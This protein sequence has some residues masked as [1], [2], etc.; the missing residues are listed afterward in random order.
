MRRMNSGPF[1]VVGNRRSGTS[2]LRLM[3][4]AHPRLCVPPEGGFV[5]FL[6]WYFGD[7]RF[8]RRVLELFLDRL[9][10]PEFNQ[11]WGLGRRELEAELLPRLP[12]GF[13]DIVDGVYRTYLSIRFPEAVRWGDK[14]TWYQ[15]HLPQLETYFPTAQYVHIVRDPRAVL[16]SY[17]KVPHL[18][19]DALEVAAD[20]RRSVMDIR[21]FGARHRCRFIEVSYEELLKHT[22]RELRRICGFLGEEFDSSMLAYH[23]LNRDL[24][25]EPARHMAWKTLTQVPP[26]ASRIL[27]WK[28]EL[29]AKDRRLVETVAVDLLRDGMRKPPSCLDVTVMGRRLLSD[30]RW[31]LRQWGWKSKHALLARRLTRSNT[32]ERISVPGLPF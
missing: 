14:T 20:W 6:G 11:D 2:L 12:C 24:G 32:R 19:D 15:H 26:D 27:A 21:R 29:T 9:L 17:R 7:R 18:S 23:E 5:V 30:L 8:D 16:A 3:L 28:N 31:Q 10:E 1:F 4:T 22:E 25:L 13:S